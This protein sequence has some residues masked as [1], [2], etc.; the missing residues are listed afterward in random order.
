M[1][2]LKTGDT[3]GVFAPSS[4]IEKADLEPSIAF[5]HA[6]GFE[7]FIH[8]QTYLR[9]RQSAGTPQ[10]KLK[11]LY[12]LW[13]DERIACIWA[14]GGGNHALHL[15][16]HIDF[17][18]LKRSNIPKPLIGF[19]DVTVLLNAF[20]AHLGTINL[21]APTL[22]RLHKSPQRNDVLAQLGGKT[23]RI[24]L[25]GA[26]C[27]TAGEARGVLIGGNLS[28]F[29]Y[30]PQTLNTA[31]NKDFWKTGILFLEDCNEELSRID[32]MALHL[33]RL[34]VFDDISALILG[35]FD[36]ILDSG[37]PYEA[38]IV[39]IFTEHLSGRTIPI[40][41]N[42]PFGHEKNLMPFPIGRKMRIKSSEDQC[43]LDFE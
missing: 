36:P 5:L 21:H 40:V 15:L 38:D 28:L 16:E 37:K 23:T 11:A 25:D 18:R 13:E 6:Q 32:R 42:A 30:L 8:P 17:A 7:V 1:F 43:F 24:P 19:S 35:S 4:W 34:G 3:I 31:A 26:Q 20:Y 9:H 27:V 39:D 22:N 14:A 41:K 12:E 29:Q 2:Q 33:K 10:D